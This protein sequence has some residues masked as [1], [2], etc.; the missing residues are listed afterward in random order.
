MSKI[1]E[2]KE[3]ELARMRAEER[4]KMRQEI[5][6]FRQDLENT[7]GKRNALLNQREN[8]LEEQFKQKKELEEREIFIQRQHLLDEMK[9]LREQ[10]AQ[11]KRS[12]EAQTKFMQIDSKKYEKMEEDVRKREE[13]LRLDQAEME[14][15]LRD[16]RQRIKL[17]LERSYAQREFIL[18]SIESKNKQEASQNEIEKSHLDRIRHE[19]QTQQIKINE[20]DLDLQKTL[21]EL[22]CL[23]QEN[24]LLKERLS[25]CM[26]YDFLV[27]ENRMLKQKL[28]I[29]KEL[30]GEKHFSS[31]RAKSILSCRDVPQ[32]KRSVTFED[33]GTNVPKL[34]LKNEDVS[35]MDTEV[36]ADDFFDDKSRQSCRD[37]GEKILDD[38]VDRLDL[39]NKLEDHAVINEEL[40]DL[41]EMQLYEQ[42][43]LYEVITDVKK[44]VEFL[45]YGVKS[46]PETVPVKMENLNFEF[47]ESTK[48]RLRYLES[49][50][51]K[52]ENNYRDYQFKIKSKYYPINDDET[53]EIRIV[54]KE[55]R[56]FDFKDLEKFLQSTIKADLKAK[57]L[58]SELNQD[59]ENVITEK[60]NR[61]IREPNFSKIEHLIKDSTIPN[62][63][64][65]R[66]NLEKEQD[67]FKNF[68]QNSKAEFLAA[69]KTESSDE[70][71]SRVM[72]KEK[73]NTIISS[74]F[75]LDDNSVSKNQTSTAKNSPV[76]QFGLNDYVQMFEN[77][78]NDELKSDNLSDVEKKQ[79][80]SRIKIEYSYSSS[81]SAK[82]DHE[83]SSS[84]E[85]KAPENK[86]NFDNDD[87]DF[88][89]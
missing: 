37:E 40:R 54:G 57:A 73:L 8:A 17:D 23:R 27:Q 56:E 28:E 89:W 88:G 13:K 9:Q 72:D 62:L 66:K 71:F 48:D 50:N 10:E 31:R 29:S 79:T 65:V 39:K 30:I 63:D 81:E 45:Q 16:E 25:H 42:R 38:A 49:E 1:A 20:M 22:M 82:S 5:Q 61:E 24:E 70:E 11:F 52:I 64:Q 78:K 14:A 83:K 15:R 68:R 60:K 69:N 33:Q 76:K 35:I 44:D 6:S 84:S 59:I 67:E 41:Y 51:E 19:Y 87:D 12:A 32:R 47:L 80:K 53:R 58:K 2:F 77:K 86:V 34:N 7:Y 18:Q 74:S 55:K 26:D 36:A 21:G 3:V 4:E 75:H 85:N 46:C 43:K